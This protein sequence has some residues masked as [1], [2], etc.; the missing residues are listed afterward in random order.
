MVKRLLSLGNSPL[1]GLFDRDG[2]KVD[3]INPASHK[4]VLDRYLH[5]KYHLVFTFVSRYILDGYGNELYKRN[6]KHII[7]TV[8]A[9]NL[10]KP[11]ES[12]AFLIR[13][14]IPTTRAEI[15]DNLDDIYDF[16]EYTDEYPFIIRTEKGSRIVRDASQAAYVL[17]SLVDENTVFPQ[18]VVENISQE[19]LTRQ[20][21]FAFGKKVIGDGD[22][23]NAIR[24]TVG[25][26]DGFV[27]SVREGDRIVYFRMIPSKEMLEEFLDNNL[28]AFVEAIT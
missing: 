25:N 27:E 2:L 4:E 14:N 28:D 19:N 1:H 9:F 7:P 3:S 10:M 23:I 6:V 17:K 26:F 24:R 21:T 8:E 5:G 12:K 20:I 11:A 13:N 18:I 22:L 15:F 16:L